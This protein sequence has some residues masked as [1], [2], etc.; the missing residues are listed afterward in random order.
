MKILYKALSKVGR[1]CS[2][3]EDLNINKYRSID[4]RLCYYDT[5]TIDVNYFS[6]PWKGVAWEE[7][8]AIE[9]K[10][11]LASDSCYSPYNWEGLRTSIAKEGLINNLM[12]V[13]NPVRTGDFKYRLLDGQHRL[14]CL[15]ELHGIDCRVLADAYVPFDYLDML[16][17]ADKNQTA[18]NKDRVQ[19]IKDKTY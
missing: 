5:I 6:Y 2:P 19:N 12:V 9:A 3:A 13:L 10:Q 18:L 7:F 11:G 4:D 15:E 17:I 1:A 14:R 8:I 16:K